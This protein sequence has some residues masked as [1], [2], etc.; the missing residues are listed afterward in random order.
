[1]LR[2]L[3]GNLGIVLLAVLLI[4]GGT[5]L[6]FYMDLPRGTFSLILCAGVTA[7]AVVLG[8]LNH[9]RLHGVYE[10]KGSSA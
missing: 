10:K 7:L 6:S 5:A 2:V 3:G 8:Q 9:F 4:V 1:M